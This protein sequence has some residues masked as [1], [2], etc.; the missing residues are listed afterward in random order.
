M[1]TSLLLFT[2]LLLSGCNSSQPG[3]SAEDGIT[4]DLPEPEAVEAN[5]QDSGNASDTLNVLV[6]TVDEADAPDPVEPQPKAEPEPAP[7]PAR[8]APKAKEAEPGS[9]TSESR[10]APPEKPRTV[11]PPDDAKLLS[12]R[13]PL[14][15]G[16]IAGT[17]ARMGHP[18]GTVTA[19][20]KVD[21]SDTDGVYKITCSS[22]D[23]YRGTDKGGH[24]FFR[25]W[26]D[27]RNRN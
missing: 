13:P 14:S 19:A 1:R 12:A 8:A 16:A 17:L 21:T 15:D 20:N 2:I 5:S 4:V 11:A 18:C 24:L 22:G 25:P 7:S 26:S 10:P 3:Q 27:R 6:P 9:E 23:S